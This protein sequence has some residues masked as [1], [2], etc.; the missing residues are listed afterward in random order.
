MSVRGSRWLPVLVCLACLFS[1][2]AAP[3]AERQCENSPPAVAPRRPS[4]LIPL[5]ASFATLQVLDAHTTLSAIDRGAEEVNPLLGGVA[6]SPARLVAVKTGL[7][8]GTIVMSERLWKQN[9]L[10]AI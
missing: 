3:A 9:R 10:G 2:T 1:A 7:V 4:V 5:Y 8:V 6:R